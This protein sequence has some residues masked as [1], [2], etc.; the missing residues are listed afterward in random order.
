MDS[1]AREGSM[2]YDFVAEKID[3]DIDVFR[4]ARR[5]DLQALMAWGAGIT[6]PLFSLSK[7][8]DPRTYSSSKLPY[9]QAVGPV[10]PGRVEFSEHVLAKVGL[11]SA[12]LAANKAWWFEKEREEAILMV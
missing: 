6:T 7:A 4:P 5:G 11:R 8:G 12:T 3:W 10:G 1:L 9:P 2:F